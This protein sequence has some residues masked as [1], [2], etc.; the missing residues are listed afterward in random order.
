MIIPLH[1]ATKGWL[2]DTIGIATRGWLAVAVPVPEVGP[3]ILI[4]APGDDGPLVLSAPDIAGPLFIDDTEIAICP[5]SMDNVPLVVSLMAAPMLTLD[6][7]PSSGQVISVGGDVMTVDIGSVHFI[8]SAV[9]GT[10]DV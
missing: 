10:E 4:S 3:V 8:I 1:V 6:I 7:D 5:V 9:A 2:D